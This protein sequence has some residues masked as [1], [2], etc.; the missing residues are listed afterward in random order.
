MVQ[1]EFGGYAGAFPQDVPERKRRPSDLVDFAYCGPNRL[2][3]TQIKGA[4]LTPGFCPP[5]VP[6]RDFGGTEA[7]AGAV[8]GS[9]VRDPGSRSLTARADRPHP[10][11]GE[12]VINP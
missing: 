10:P 11:I 4:G 5:H 2:A 12:G 3:L 6:E 7:S 9:V 1:T 8:D